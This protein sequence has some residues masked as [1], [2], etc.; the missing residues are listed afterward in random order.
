[1]TWIIG[2]SSFTGYGVM[3]S[4]V[5]V[6]FPNR[7]TRDMIRKAYP[8]GNHV[9]GGFSGSVRIGFTLLQSL[10][11]FL[12]IA[13]EEE[14]TLSWDPLFIAR[15]WPSIARQVFASCPN[16]ETRLGS[17]ILLVAISPNEDRGAPEFPKVYLI[18]FKSP[19]FEAGIVTRAF[20]AL[21]IG[22]GAGAFHY[23]RALKDLCRISSGSHKAE[24]GKQFGWADTLCF[25]LSRSAIDHPIAGVSQHFHLLAFNRHD[26][27][28]HNSDHRTHSKDLPTP[29][30]HKMPPVATSYDEFLSMCKCT[31]A[32]AAEAIC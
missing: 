17:S 31:N 9:V 1:M 20:Q 7:E 13:P 3:I 19:N 32:Q 6:T 8:L 24:I 18:R 2:T 26:L 16:A 14:Q 23:K 12:R 28:D 22:S 10:A 15:E 25:S 11:D 5:Q 21:S 27:L 4:D 29:I 30:E